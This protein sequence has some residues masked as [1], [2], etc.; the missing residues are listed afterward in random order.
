MADY[1]LIFDAHLDLAWNAIDWNRDLK[2]TVAEIRRRE[3]EGK[4]NGKG[5][6]EGTVSFPDLR[7]GK[8]GLFIATLLARLHRPGMMPAFTR[9]DNMDAAYAA[10]GKRLTSDIEAL[11]DLRASLRGRILA[12]PLFDAPRFARNLEIAIREMWRIWCA[13]Q[14]RAL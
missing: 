5:R 8:V 6:G 12:S 11:A 10:T 14:R 2:L 3:I 7:R 13:A 4:I 1:P 9:Y